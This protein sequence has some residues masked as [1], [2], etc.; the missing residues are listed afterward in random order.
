MSSKRVSASK[1]NKLSDVAKKCF[2]VCSDFPY[3]SAC[4]PFCNSVLVT[5]CSTIAGYMLTFLPPVLLLFR[6]MRRWYRRCTVRT[7]LCNL[8]LRC[9]VCTHSTRWH[10]QLA[11]TPPST[12]SLVTLSLATVQPSCL[13]LKPSW[14][15]Y[16]GT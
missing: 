15:A 2:E 8:S 13:N 10:V 6:M 1:M 14:R 9:P 3:G 7:K 5:T 16:F 4:G 11:A 12:G